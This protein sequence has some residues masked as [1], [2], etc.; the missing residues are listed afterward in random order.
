MSGTV[1]VSWQHLLDRCSQT[2]ATK[3][4]KLHV[5]IEHSPAIVVPRPDEPGFFVRSRAA[6]GKAWWSWKT[7]IELARFKKLVDARLVTCMAPLHIHTDTHRCGRKHL[8][9]PDCWCRPAV[10]T[11]TEGVDVVNHTGLPAA[12]VRAGLAIE[13]MIE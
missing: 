6:K 3:P 10:M 2:H 11:T 12:S 5:T 9:S 13:G 1:V 8:L 4:R 7:E